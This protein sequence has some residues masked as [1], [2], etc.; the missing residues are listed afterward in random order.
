MNRIE[1]CD[2]SCAYGKHL[3][4]REFSIEVQAG[5][6]LALLGPNGSGKTTALRSLARMLKPR[7]GKV[8]LQD[9]DIWNQSSGAVARQLAMTPQVE[10]RD[11]PISVEHAVLLG[12]TPHRGWFLPYN[13]DD[14]RQADLAIK[15]CGLD[16]LRERAVTELS[17]G[18]WRRVVLARTLA[19]QPSTLLLDEPLANLD[20]K[21]QH[22]LLRFVRSL[23]K[24]DSIS[25]VVTM[26]D[27]NTAAMFADRIG[28]LSDGQ[29]IALG[30]PTEVCTAD[31]IAKAFDVEVIVAKHPV[32]DTPLITPANF[33]L[34]PSREEALE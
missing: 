7:Q 8:L 26:H 6:V 32:F 31:H 33:D 14:R 13:S 1:A 12:R 4:L 2:V 30:T 28:L 19:Q 3:A 9:A 25:V 22:E 34:G 5:E 27:L 10:R 24:D 18:E 15:Q 29:L 17:G 16:T 23:V 21:Y 11:W 20:L